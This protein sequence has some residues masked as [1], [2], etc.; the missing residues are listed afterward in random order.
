[1]NTSQDRAN[2]IAAWSARGRDLLWII[3]LGFLT[4]IV[5]LGIISAGWT[6]ANLAVSVFLIFT[7]ILTIT[8]ALDSMDDIN[9]ISQDAQ[10]DEAELKAQKRFVDTQWGMFKGL[11]VAGF[12]LTA[13][14]S[15]YAMWI[16]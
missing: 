3:T 10:P 9:A 5:V 6:T 4:Q 1:M 16:A 8:G 11:I 13:I 14:A 15:L 12:G 7:T 2:R